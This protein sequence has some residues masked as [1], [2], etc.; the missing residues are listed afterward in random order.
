[1]S[2][3]TLPDN[4]ACIYLFYTSLFD[5]TK[6]YGYKVADNVLKDFAGLVNSMGDEN[7]FIG[8]NGAGRFAAFL[9]QCNAR[10]AKAIIDVFDTQI[11]EYN[12]L[13]PDYRMEYKAAYAVSTDDG[14]YEIRGLFRTAMNKTQKKD[15]GEKAGTDAQKK[16][17]GEQTATPAQ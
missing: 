1:M 9:P 2:K 12:N 6:K 16:D 11:R 3:E 13:N 17:E 7:T 15:E 4:Y 5:H 14:E 8:Y 10:R